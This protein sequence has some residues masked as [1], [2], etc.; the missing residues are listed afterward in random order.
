MSGNGNKTTMFSSE[1][2]YFCYFKQK[3]A[4]EMR[5]SDWS[6]DVCSSDLRDARGHLAAATST[7]GLTNKHPGRVGD[8]P[9]IGAG[10]FADDRSAAIS[11]TGTG[12]SFIRVGF[13]SEVDAQIR[14]RETTL[15]N[16]TAH[17]LEIGR[18]HV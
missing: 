11:C 16:A 18:A 8:T 2:V 13:G 17:A 12:E 4:Y 5:I 10:T 6:S 15:A 3:T 7:G 9:I 1:E 14:Y